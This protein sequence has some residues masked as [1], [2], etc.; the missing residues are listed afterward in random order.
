MNT[1]GNYDI[2]ECSLNTY[3]SELTQ[4]YESMTQGKKGLSYTTENNSSAA[5]LGEDE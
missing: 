1:N 3:L 2:D 5:F 4:Q